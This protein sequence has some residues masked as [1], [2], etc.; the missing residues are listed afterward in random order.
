MGARQEPVETLAPL[1]E[2][3][4]RLFKRPAPPGD[5]VCECCMEPE[6]K[7]RFLQW[8][9]RDIPLH[10]LRDW[11]FAAPEVPF[12]IVTMRWLLPRILDGLA[13]GEELA[14]V[15]HEVVLHRLTS[16]GFPDDW[17][18]D[19]VELI[20]RFGAALAEAV[21]SGRY[22]GDRFMEL[23]ECL[24]MLALGGIGLAPVF[25][26]LDT[27]DPGHLARSVGYLGE[28]AGDAFWPD[29]P[30]QRDAALAW[31]YS[32]AMANRLMT[33]GVGDGPEELRNDALR[34]AEQILC[35]PAYPA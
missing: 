16:A 1:V 27:V 26:R 13:R 8:P 17:K 20:N 5:G 14:S 3:A 33:Y 9:V 32:E 24:C 21:A 23:D 11:Y 30:E 7:A 25:K 18:D 2:E 29:A 6:I 4:Y 10:D 22:G 35:H 19:E 28:I 15:G 34:C 12:P 31:F